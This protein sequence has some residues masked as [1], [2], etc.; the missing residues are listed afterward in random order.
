MQKSV[1]STTII[2]LFVAIMPLN[3][4]KSNDGVGLTIQNARPKTATLIAV[5]PVVKLT[6]QL[7]LPKFNDPSLRLR[8][9]LFVPQSLYPELYTYYDS[10]KYYQE[11]NERGLYRDAPGDLLFGRFMEAIF[12]KVFGFN[13]PTAVF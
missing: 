6:P 10:R 5:K 13:P 1:F 12:V 11:V 9:N 8:T 7:D 4:Q 2:G 3:A